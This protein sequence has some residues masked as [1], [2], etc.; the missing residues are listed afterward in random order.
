MDDLVRE[1]RELKIAKEYAL[2][3]AISTERVKPH[4]IIAKLPRDFYAVNRELMKKQTS[5]ENEDAEA[6]MLML[7]RIRRGKI[8]GLADALKLDT[9]ISNLLT[10][11]EQQYY[12]SIYDSGEQFEKAVLQGSEE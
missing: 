7:F 6:Q 2:A 11:E 1:Y 10:Y 9:A 3:P 8:I 12:T 4:H 5:R